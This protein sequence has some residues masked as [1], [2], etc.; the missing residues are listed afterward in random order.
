[1]P[2]QGVSGKLRGNANSMYVVYLK[3][4]P[5]ILSIAYF[6]CPVVRKQLCQ[7]H[8]IVSQW[9][10][11]GSFQYDNGVSTPFLR[12]GRIFLC[13]LTPPPL[14]ASLVISVLSLGSAEDGWGTRKVSRCPRG[15]SPAPPRRRWALGVSRVSLSDAQW[16]GGLSRGPLHA[17]LV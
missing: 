15:K 5:F 2:L 8:D 12:V 13:V 1:M 6:N 9:G 17:Y 7:D 3:P 11:V 14:S 10:D 16:V 4:L